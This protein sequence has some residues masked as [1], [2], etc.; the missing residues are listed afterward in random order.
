MHTLGQIRSSPGSFSRR[1]RDYVTF[2]ALGFGVLSLSWSMGQR[3]L[4]GQPEATVKRA[5]NLV[6]TENRK[7]GATDWQLT[8]IRA[9]GDGFR[10][11][12]I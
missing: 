3:A 10:S 9:D 4:A 8:R 6:V 12:W 11:P 5:A 7:P 1:R 2:I